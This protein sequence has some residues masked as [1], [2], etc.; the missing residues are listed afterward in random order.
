MSFYGSRRDRSLDN[1]PQWERLMLKADR[2]PLPRQPAHGIKPRPA[3]DVAYL[4]KADP[5]NHLLPASQ[6]WLTSMPVE[7]RPQ[8]L[9]THYARIVNLIAQHW[10]D[11]DACAAYFNDLLIDHRGNRQGF[12]APVQADIRALQQYFLHSQQPAA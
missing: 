11:R 7:A 10:N 8:A 12:P 9:T 2:A 1:D 5:A 6:R 4:R 3:Q